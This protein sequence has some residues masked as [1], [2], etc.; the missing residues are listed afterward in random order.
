MI[1]TTSKK[2][3]ASKKEEKIEEKTAQEYYE[4][5]NFER[6]VRTFTD[7]LQAKMQPANHLILPNNTAVNEESYQYYL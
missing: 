3:V 5:F 7:F 1:D 2:Q 4:A 6:T